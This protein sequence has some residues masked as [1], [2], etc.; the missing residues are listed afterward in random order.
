MFSTPPII[1]ATVI[2]SGRAATYKDV[3]A[4]GFDLG[5]GGTGS[6]LVGWVAQQV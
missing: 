3:T 4:T 5:A 2:G 6:A 1:T